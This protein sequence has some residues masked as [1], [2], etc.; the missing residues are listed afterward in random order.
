M[1]ILMF[2]RGVIAT[3]YGWALE[4][5][6]HQVEFY[7]RPG[8]AAEYGSTVDVDLLDARKSPRGRP[9]AETW[10]V[11]YREQLD[12]DHDF[13][14]IVVSVPHTRLTEAAEF[15]APR[16]GAATVLIFGNIWAEPWDAVGD[17]PRDQVA[18][19]FPGGGG[20]FDSEG[21]LRAGMLPFVVLGTIDR[22]P[23]ERERAVRRVFRAAG[24]RVQEQPD[25]RG[26]LWIH[27][28]ADA[29]MFT[30]PGPLTDLIGNRQGLRDALLTTRELLPVL[31]ARGIDLRRH[32]GATLPYRAPAGATAAVMAWATGSFALGRRSLEMH[33]DP[34]APEEIAVRADTL[35]EARRRGVAVPRLAAAAG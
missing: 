2:G 10:P 31:R 22:A 23:T 32:L 27:F 30:P 14:L 7:V 24:F 34:R 4:R 15:L 9:V 6:G 17:L 35:A 25:F 13:D 29:G 28:I 33:T 20:G 8:R 3:T 26:W 12:A 1:K 11:R 18:W 5:A 19:G 16:I 21:V